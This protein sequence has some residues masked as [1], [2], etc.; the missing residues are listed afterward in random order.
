MIQIAICD[1]ERHIQGCLE[2]MLLELG[3]VKNLKL[4]ME[5]FEDGEEIVQNV[6]DGQ[7]FDIIFMDI[8][9]KTV[10][11]IKAAEQIRKLDK[12]VQ[13]IYVTSHDN[14]MRDVFKVAPIGFLS[15]PL[16]R[17]EVEHQFL[18]A[19]NYVKNQDA[20]Y[21]F[22][23]YKSHYQVPVRDIIYFHGSLRDMEIVCENEKYQQYAKLSD[24]EKQLALCNC[25]FIR[26]HRSYLVNRR[27]IR[28]YAYE[29]IYL[30][31]GDI[32]P[33]GRTYIKQIQTALSKECKEI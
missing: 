11:G 33:I 10:D 1:D 30:H 23:Y 21:R 12:G 13:I 3:K 14:Y 26:I 24:A 32:L 17:E 15:K 20:Y 7:R 27:Y 18:Y 22:K 9:M 29:N 5:F 6:T 16:K 28:K 19:V 31:N 2:T 25:E 8:K 4:E